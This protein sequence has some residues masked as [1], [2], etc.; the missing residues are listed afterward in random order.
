MAS[1]TQCPHPGCYLAA[2]FG[3]R[4]GGPGAGVPSTASPWPGVSGRKVAAGVD[5]SPRPPAESRL[6]PP[7]P[8]SLPST[9]GACALAQAASVTEWTSLVSPVLLGQPFTPTLAISRKSGD[10][11]LGPVSHCGPCGDQASRDGFKGCWP[12][13]LCPERWGHPDLTCAYPWTASAA[14]VHVAAEAMGDLALAHTSRRQAVAAAAA[15]SSKQ[16]EVRG[17]GI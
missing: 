6:P 12:T 5:P 11:L 14:R 8:L 16:I 13:A 1:S 9:H 10:R 7:P 15:S 3:P 17:R 4:L 2:S